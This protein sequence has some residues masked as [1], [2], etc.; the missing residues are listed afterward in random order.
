MNKWRLDVEALYVELDRRRRGDRLK[1]RDVATEAH[2]SASTLT[3]M[4]YGKSPSADG[5]IALMMW[6][7][8]PNLSQF[9]TVRDDGKA[10]RE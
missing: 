10:T 1:W 5:L 6:L 9:I 7:G 8:T 4:G 2:I 3:R